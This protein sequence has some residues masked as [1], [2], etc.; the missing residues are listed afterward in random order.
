MKRPNTVALPRPKTATAG[1]AR[2]RKEAAIQLVRL[3]FDISRIER[4]MTLS[5]QRMKACSS[6]LAVY[7]AERE[8]LMRMLKP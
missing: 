4:A 5:R 1:T 6:E 3:E 2:T 7:T 8:K